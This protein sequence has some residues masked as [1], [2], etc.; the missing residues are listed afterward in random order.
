MKTYAKLTPEGTRDYL[1]EECD[2][3]RAVERSFSDLFKAHGYRRVMTPAFEFYDVFNRESAGAL[4]ETLYTMTDAY[5]RL[6]AL[7]ADSTLPIARMA[8]TRLQGADLPIRLYYNQN[9][10]TRRPKLSGHNDEIAQS[11]IELIGAAGLRADLEVL[12]MAIAALDACSAENYTIEIGHAGYFKALCGALDCDADTIDEIYTCMEQKNYVALQ[13]VLDKI[14]STPITDA[15]RNLP[16]M[17]GGKEMLQAAAQV[18]TAAQAQE[19]IAYLQTLYARLEQIG[20]SEKIILDLSLVHRSNYYTGM[21]FRGYIAGSGETVLSGGRYDTLLQEFGANLPATG[22]GLQIDA[23]ARLKLEKGDIAA[24]PA[25]EYLIFGADGFEP[26]A[27]MAQNR[28]IQAGKTCE[29][30]VFETEAAAK[31]YASRRGISKLLCIDANGEREV[32]L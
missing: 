31:A 5:G 7:R 15:L 10:Y 24:E 3:R 1:F 13:T 23:L 19:A 4:P 30:S 32:V 17:F 14:G 9:V 25:P 20:L 16:K 22:F 2:A 18:C 6:L 27:L 8:A 26:A 29:H 12:T 21:I 11:G 28:L